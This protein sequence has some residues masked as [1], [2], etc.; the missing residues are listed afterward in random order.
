MVSHSL[1][2]AGPIGPCNQLRLTSS[3]SAWLGSDRRP[4]QN[5]LANLRWI[6]TTRGGII[7]RSRQIDKAKLAPAL[8]LPSLHPAWP[9]VENLIQK[10]KKVSVPIGQ[11]DL[12]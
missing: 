2:K 9:A 1:L 6:Q 3:A 10:F 5:R 11:G 4:R 8:H 12:G 7:K